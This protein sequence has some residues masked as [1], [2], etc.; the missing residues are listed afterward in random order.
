MSGLDLRIVS[1][2]PDVWFLVV[3]VVGRASWYYRIAVQTSSSVALSP[4]GAVRTSSVSRRDIFRHK[5]FEDCV[6]VVEGYGPHHLYFWYPHLPQCI[7]A[8]GQL[9]WVTFLN[10]GPNKDENMETWQ[11]HVADLTGDDQTTQ[12]IQVVNLFLK[13]I[14]NIRN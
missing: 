1:W 3:A 2:V 8:P 7:L 14:L 11:L 6:K 12:Y 4:I 5:G 13:N 10:I 9:S